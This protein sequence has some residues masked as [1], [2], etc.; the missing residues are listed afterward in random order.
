[1]IGTITKA[2]A[3][4]APVTAQ[5]TSLDCGDSKKMRQLTLNVRLVFNYS[6][7]SENSCACGL[8]GQN[9]FIVKRDL[10]SNI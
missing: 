10:F 5:K 6:G 9:K 3:A 2:A 8:R 4:Y 1:M 7:M